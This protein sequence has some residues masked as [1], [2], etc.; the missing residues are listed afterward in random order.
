[1]NWIT[2]MSAL[3]LA[4]V[5]AATIVIP[6]DQPI[7]KLYSLIQIFGTIGGVL[8]AS[9]AGFLLATSSDTSEREKAKT[10]IGGVLMGLCIIWAAPWIVAY[11]VGGGICGW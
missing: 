6:P 2:T 7:C 10:Y 11:L 5:A 8:L 3:A 4:G 9:Y 1:M